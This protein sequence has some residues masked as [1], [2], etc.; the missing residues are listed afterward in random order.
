M[1]DTESASVNTV[2]S[3]ADKRQ[4]IPFFK[5]QFQR[6]KHKGSRRNGSNHRTDGYKL[7]GY[8]L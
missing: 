1:M 3:S 4:R 2:A 5:H 6:S 8:P 7:Y